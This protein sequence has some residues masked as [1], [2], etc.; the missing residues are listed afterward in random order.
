MRFKPNGT[1]YSTFGDQGMVRIPLSDVQIVRGLHLPEGDILLSAPVFNGSA[2]ALMV[3]RFDSTGTM[4]PSWGNGG[5]LNTGITAQHSNYETFLALQSDGKL[6]LVSETGSN[7]RQILLNRL[8]L[9]GSVDSSYGINGSSVSTFQRGF[10]VY[11]ISIQPDNKILISGRPGDG[12]GPAFVVR[13]KSAGPL[14]YNFAN[15]GT[16]EFGAPV[17]QI[18]MFAFG[19]AI[20]EPVDSTIWAVGY[21]SWGGA[22]TVVVKFTTAAHRKWVNLG[23][24]ISVCAGTLVTLNAQNSGASFLWTNSATSQTI[25]PTT[26][27]T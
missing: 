17:G 4:L 16:L 22:H 9:N 13:F 19:K 20:Y 5:I 18:D 10:F 21:N 11:G 2:N 27:G 12:G 25:S 8:K 14:D 24:D 1:F 23:S 6:I 15:N 26:S 3:L 7:P